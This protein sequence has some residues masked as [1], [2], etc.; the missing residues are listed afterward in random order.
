MT[1]AQLTALAGADH[2][3]ATDQQ[4]RSVR[5][6]GHWDPT[7][8]VLVRNRASDSGDNGYEVVTPLL[9]VAGGT[10]LLVDRGWI[11]AG[12]TPAQPDAVPAPQDGQVTVVARLEAAEPSRPT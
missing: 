2:A 10:A 11:P 6:S 7:H 12:T 9:P 5:V 8:Q 4:W 3:F 1:M